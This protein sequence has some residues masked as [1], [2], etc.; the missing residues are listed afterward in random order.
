MTSENRVAAVD[1]QRQALKLRMEGRTFDEIAKALKYGGPSGAYKA[2]ITGLQKTLQGPAS[3]LR[4]L[5]AERLDAL[6]ASLWRRAGRPALGAVDRC[7]SIMERRAKLLGLDAPMKVDIT[8]RLRELAIAQ[9]LDPDKAVAAA[10]S[11]VRGHQ[12]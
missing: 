7:L 2:V 12:V 10:E 4:A 5:E 8:T 3:G 11:I 9:G 1:R 6:L